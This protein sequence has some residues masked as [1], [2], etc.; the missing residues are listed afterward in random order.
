MVT[1]NEAQNWQ[2]TKKLEIFGHL[3]K[4]QTKTSKK[5]TDGNEQLYV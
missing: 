3:W 2:E 5:T 1:E 4:A